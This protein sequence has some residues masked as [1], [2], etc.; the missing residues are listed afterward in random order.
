MKNGFTFKNR[1]SSEFGAVA[2]TKSRPMI[3]EQKIY[4]YDVPL[5]HGEW[6]FTEKNPFGRTFYK[7]RLIQVELSIYAGSI[8][9]LERKA[10]RIAMWLTGSGYLIFDDQ[11]AVKWLARVSSDVSFVPEHGG[12]SAVMDVVFKTD[13]GEA[14]FDLSEGMKLGDAIMLDSAVPFN[15]ADYY[16]AELKEGSNSVLFVNMGD[17]EARPI[18]EFEGEAVSI[19][20]VCGDNQLSFSNLQYTRHIIDFE[21][22]T[23]VSESDGEVY[24][25]IPNMNGAFFDFPTGDNEITV[26]SDKAER[27]TIHHVPKT[28]YDFDL[29]AVKWGG[30]NA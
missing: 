11:S 13:M 1:H 16:S 19:Q 24:N 22:C 9:S 14:T 18:L 2:K 21:K 26:I 23:A 6:D 30:E 28:I 12:K 17:I 7:S 25:I 10:A 3:P 29:A 27:L 4:S 20:I 5:M 15:V 8:R